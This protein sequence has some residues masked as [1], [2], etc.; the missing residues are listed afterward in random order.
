MRAVK[1]FSGLIQ[2]FK[3]LSRFKSLKEFN[4]HIEQ[5]MVD[6]KKYFTKA[7]LQAFKRLV[8]FSCKYKG[9]ANA[10]IGTMLKY[11]YEIEGGNGISRSSFN[12]MLAKAK[13]FGI[14]NVIHTYRKAEHGRVKQSH[15]V[16]VFN[17][18]FS[19]IEIPTKEKL[20]QQ[21]ISKEETNKINKYIELNRSYHERRL[22]ERQAVAKNIPSFRSD[23]WIKELEQIEERRKRRTMHMNWLQ[24]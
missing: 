12:R 22:K 9:I 6:Y 1:V 7:E 13:Q 17:S 16:Y 11:N 10:K 3:D 21:E 15:S 4:N 18:Y 20:N 19:T 2:K 14:L 24:N 23:S 5:W 8:R